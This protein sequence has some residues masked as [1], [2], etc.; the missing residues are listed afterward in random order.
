MLPVRL[1]SLNVG[2]QTWA[3]PVP[4]PVVA[5]PFGQQPDVL[6]P[7]EYVK[8]DGRP[9]LRAALI[10][11]GLHHVASS[12][13]VQRQGRC[14]WNQ[15]LIASRWPITFTSDATGLGPCNGSAFLSVETGGMAVTGVR[16]PMWVKASDWYGAWERLLL[17][18][19]GDLLIGDLNIDPQRKRRRDQK[20]LKALQ[21]A[22]WH[23]CP[24]D[25]PWSYKG[26]TGVASVVDHA[27]ARGD[28]DV[29]SAR[30][31]AEGIAGVGPV[32]HAALA[33]EVEQG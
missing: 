22:G 4:N 29:L 10:E 9:D 18:F 33:V 5:A 26:N 19:L 3:R 13:R 28:V 6:L 8:G 1:L 24:A 25:G 27:F 14:W 31:V 15:V 7:V 20:P 23:W 2:H 30:Y 16:V 32:D 17:R 21:E 12:A 11:A